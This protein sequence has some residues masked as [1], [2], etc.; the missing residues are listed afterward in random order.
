MPYKSLK[1]ISD[2]I[3][4]LLCE[5]INRSIS[6]GTFPTCL[7]VANVIPIPKEGDLLELCNHR[8]IS[9]LPDFSKL[10]EK[11]IHFQLSN[12]FE[13]EG[14]ISRSQYGFRAGKS[15]IQAITSQLNFIYKCLND[16]QNIF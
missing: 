8:P 12:Y 11:V 7:E 10:F 3:A 5:L 15:T 16:D 6:S 9:L 2:I 13:V 14:I 1:D 4:P